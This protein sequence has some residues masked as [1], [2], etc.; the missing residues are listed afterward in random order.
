MPCRV[1][2]KYEDKSK[3]FDCVLKIFE[4]VYNGKV[5]DYL[6]WHIYIFYQDRYIVYEPLECLDLMDGYYDYIKS[7]S[8]N[9]ISDIYICA[10]VDVPYGSIDRHP[11]VLY[12]TDKTM[13]PDMINGID[14][15]SPIRSRAENILHLTDFN[16]IEET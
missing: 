8:I 16:F 15:E 14:E 13:V 12:T 9:D 11:R 4:D 5:M 2:I 7:H 3:L 6:C 10:E 1:R